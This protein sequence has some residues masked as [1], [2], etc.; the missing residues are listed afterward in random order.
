MTAAA[1]V[2]PQGKDGA[3]G[4]KGPGGRPGQQV[5][6]RNMHELPCS[7]VSQLQCSPYRPELY[8]LVC[9]PGRLHTLTYLLE[10]LYA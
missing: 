8:T 1:V 7:P 6:S 3:T 9:F 4:A 5:S 2:L 10:Y